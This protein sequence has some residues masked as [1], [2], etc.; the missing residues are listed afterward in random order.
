VS[1]RLIASGPGRGS[2]N[3][4][5]DEAIFRSVAAGAGPPALRFYTWA[6]AALS[7]GYAQDAEREVDFAACRARRVDVVRRITGGR[8]VLHDAELTYSV[9]CGSDAERFGGSVA[10]AFGRVA[11]GLVEG[12]RLLGLAEARAVTEPCRGGARSRHPGCF[13][14]RAAQ[15]IEVRGRKLVGSAQRRERGAFLQH[16]SILLR[17]HGERLRALLRGSGAGEQEEA[18]AGLAD[19]LSPCPGPS[20]VSAAIAAGCAGAWDVSFD[21]AGPTPQELQLARRL[22]REKYRSCGWTAKRLEK[23]HLVDMIPPRPYDVPA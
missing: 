10:T 9:A 22:E 5:L 6:P 3:L 8:A 15:E 20:E 11:E 18:M 1:W 16:G 19:F 21:P 2:W 13:A 4:A 12:L 7:L 14:S 17:G 23:P